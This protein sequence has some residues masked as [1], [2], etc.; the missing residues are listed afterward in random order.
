[1]ARQCLRH[2]VAHALGCRRAAEVFRITQPE[3]AQLR[4]ARV[5]A[6]GEF[7]G[8]VPIGHVRRDL[9]GREPR[10]QPGQGLDVVV[11]FLRM[12]R[13]GAVAVVRGVQG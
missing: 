13:R 9:L 5:Q 10:D 1:M 6:A 7:A 8:A 2:R 4:G 12:R 11:V 3:Q